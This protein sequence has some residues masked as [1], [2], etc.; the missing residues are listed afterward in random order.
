MRRDGGARGARQTGCAFRVSHQRSLA[1]QLAHPPGFARGG[2]GRAPRGGRHHRHARHRGPSGGRSPGRR[3]RPVDPQLRARGHFRPRSRTVAQGRSRH[4]VADPELLPAAPHRELPPRSRSPPDRDGS[5]P[6]A[7]TTLAASR[8][9]R[10]GWPDEL[11][12]GGVGEAAPIRGC[13]MAFR[14]VRPAGAREWLL[15]SPLREKGSSE[16]R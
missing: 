9:K 2:G 6:G 3:G 10:A 13:W 16:T 1:A 5:A 11:R 7:V 4:R 15:G 12:L 8:G 14:C